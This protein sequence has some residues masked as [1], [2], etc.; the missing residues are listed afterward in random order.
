MNT[1]DY[2]NHSLIERTYAKYLLITRDRAESKISR[3]SRLRQMKNVYR[4]LFNVMAERDSC[5]DAFLY[6][7]W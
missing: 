2:V 5:S 4:V 1:H 7:G 3:N 6:I